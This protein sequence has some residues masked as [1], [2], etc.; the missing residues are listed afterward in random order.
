M[1]SQIDV[2]AFGLPSA[3]AIE[4]IRNKLRIP[5]ERWDDVR[6][7]INAKGFAVAG[8]TK[9]DIIKE[10]HDAITEVIET[11]GSITDF[12]RQ[13]DDIVQRH[14]WK[15]R[16]K[17]GWRTSVIYDTN[18]RSAHMAGRWSQMQETKAQRP[19][20]QYIT[21]G[22]GRVRPEH[23]RWNSIILP[24][25]HPFWES[26]YPPNGWG[27]RCTVRTLSERDMARR[28]LSVSKAPQIR[29]T[30]RVNAATGEVYGDVPEGIDVGWDYNVG[31]AWLGPEQALEEKLAQLPPNIRANVFSATV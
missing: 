9:A 8:A 13:F 27:C 12:R 26:H 6:G 20:L 7:E 1:P 23:A 25:D 28:G 21:V 22:D 5:S 10:M 18:L 4:N 2:D 15:Y 24:I 11:G 16:G 31:K 14:G 17:R 30:E 19:Y 29:T 3:R